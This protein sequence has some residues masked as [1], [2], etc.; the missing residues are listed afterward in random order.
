MCDF[1][2]NLRGS[3]PHKHSDIDYY[4][5]DSSRIPTEIFAD[6][7]SMLATD[8]CKEPLLKELVDIIKRNFY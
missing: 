2:G 6:I 4:Y 7:S 5:K 3:H 1:N 8:E